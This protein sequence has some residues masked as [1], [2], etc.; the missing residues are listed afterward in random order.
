[1]IVSG[2]FVAV[3]A[4]EKV[5]QVSSGEPP[6][7]WCRDGVVAGLERGEPLPDLVGVGEVVRRYDLALDDGE[8]DLALVEPG[9]VHRGVDQ[10]RGGPCLAHPVDRGLAPV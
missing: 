1:M 2:V 7:E 6:S 9:G 5:P 10:V 8:V 4:L 3:D